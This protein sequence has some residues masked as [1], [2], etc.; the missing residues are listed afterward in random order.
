ML[1]ANPFPGERNMGEALI[2]AERDFRKRA[3]IEG[4][5]VGQI[6]PFWHSFGA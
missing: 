6:D 5:F 1:D 4:A 2:T 3:M